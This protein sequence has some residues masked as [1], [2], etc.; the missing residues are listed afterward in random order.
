MCGM[1]GINMKKKRI[2]L[3]TSSLDNGG[4]EKWVLNTIYNMDRSDIEIAYYF[5]GDIRQDTFLE[6]YNSMGIKTYFRKLNNKL[7]P[8]FILLG[9]DLTHFIQLTGPYDA[10]HVN[11]TKLLYQAI[12]MWVSRK[13]EIPVRIVHCHSM[14]S[15]N[16]SGIKKYI[17]KLLRNSIKHNATCIAACTKQAGQAK[18]GKSIL[19]SSKFDVFKNGIDLEQYVFSEEKRK[20]L[21][22][23][24]NLENTFVL[25]HIGRMEYEKNHILLLKIFKKIT[26]YENRAKL[27]LV[28]NGTLE[29]SIF[30]Y[31]KQLG[32]SEKIIHI[33]YT[34]EPENY[35]SVADVFILPS[36]YEGQPLVLLEALANGLPRVVS[37]GVPQLV[38][39]DEHMQVVSL[40]APLNEWI[41]AIENMRK[42]GRYTD[43]IKNLRKQ[44]YDIKQT[45]AHVKQI[46]CQQCGGL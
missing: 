43:G 42:E 21:R 3:I 19:K 45:A 29:R 6:K 11:G 37:D 26:E 8:V 5:W 22:K 28:G 33:S 31:A 14:A 23:K 25:L 44:G 34:Q 38:N 46:L 27:L 30:N 32:I 17:R 36:L 4:A 9:M 41:Y 2:L 18:Y 35:Y 15:S 40:K 12:C 39:L 1:G 7:L 13:A 24:Y 10:I 20:I 16:L